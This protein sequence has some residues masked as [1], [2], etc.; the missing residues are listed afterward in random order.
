MKNV[1]LVAAGAQIGIGRAHRLFGARRRR[2]GRLPGEFRQGH[3]LSPTVDRYD[4]KQY[5]ELYGDAGG[6]RCGHARGQPIPSGI[7]K[8]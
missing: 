6:G 3:A 1:R 7:S 5:R 8:C 4:N 2:Q